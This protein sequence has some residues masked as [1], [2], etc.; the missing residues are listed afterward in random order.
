M[1][2]VCVPMI[3]HQTPSKIG[4]VKSYYDTKNNENVHYCHYCGV[5]FP[6]NDKTAEKYR[7]HKG[8]KV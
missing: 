1:E 8:D 2:H 6:I 7:Y 4:F 3:K 5:T